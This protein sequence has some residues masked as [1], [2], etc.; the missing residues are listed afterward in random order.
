MS[1][2]RRSAAGRGLFAALAAIVLAACSADGSDVR[3]AS[4]ATSTTVVR[5]AP[6]TAVTS[7]SSTTSTI[8]APVVEAVS[9]A[10]VRAVQERLAELG[11]DVGDPDGRF[12]GRTSYAIMAFQKIEGLDRTG[13]IDDGLQAALAAAGPPGPLAGGP[14]TRVEIDLN[15]Q[16]LM[17]WQSGERTR[18]L[19]I[20]SGNG[21]EY[22]VD[23]EC[24]IAVTPPGSFHIGRKAEG[25]EIAPLGELW[26]PMYF[27]GGI[28]IHGS[29][30]VPPY[31]ASHGCIRIPMYAAPTLYDQ[32]GRGTAVILV[33]RGP[34]PEGLAAPPEP[35]PNPVS[36]STLPPETDPPTLPTLPPTTE[37]PEEPVVTTTSTTIE[38]TTTT[39]VTTPK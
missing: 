13:D 36:S 27:N 6:S 15:R 5:A 18:I 8:A 2:V 33:G 4:A 29:P 30:S 23:G 34:G 31:P 35:P 25:L 32:V 28:A 3:A 19:P 12:G 10:D 24:D 9:S 26:W 11:Y 20:S 22:C 38:A 17:L 16:V 39:E 7:T 37:P 21:E 14:G 1:G